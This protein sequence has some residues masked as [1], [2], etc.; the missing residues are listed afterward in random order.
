MF[1]YLITLTPLGLLY[2]SAGG[3]L[4]PENLVGRSQAKFPPDSGAFAGLL[5]DAKQRSHQDIDKKKLTVAGPFWTHDDLWA[6]RDRD[7]FVPLPR[8]KVVGKQPGDF[9]TWRF[10]RNANPET[11]RVWKRDPKKEDLQSDYTWVQLHNWESKAQDL[12]R[13]GAR[14]TNVRQAPWTF[15]PMLHPWM[16]ADERCVQETGGLFLEQA[17]RMDDGVR[18][19]YA[20]TEALADGWYKFGGENHLVETECV[21]IDETHKLNALLSQ[22][23]GDSFAIVTPAIWGSNRRSLRHPH[24]G[25]DTAR[26]E[27]PPLSPF[28]YRALLT[29]KPVP[30]RFRSGGQDRSDGQERP[31]RLGRGRYAIK[32]G[33]VY[34]LSEARSDNW[35]QWERWFPREGF[36]LQR[37]GCGLALPM[38]V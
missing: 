31:G 19:V 36:S 28:P 32:A 26:P 33:S 3:F 18:L 10:D 13:D 30:F 12:N 34:V 6:G 25:C 15:V 4:S 2:G 37:L 22:E 27:A 8:T 38:P 17:V 11:G 9:D 14:G 7:F 5:L 1:H 21:E 23:I 20:S 24:D 35:W 16:K 29:D